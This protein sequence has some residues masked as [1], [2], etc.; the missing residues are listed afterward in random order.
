[1]AL[2][3]AEAQAQ[4]DLLIQ[5]LGGYW[6]PLANLARL[7]E[8]C[9]ELARLVNQ[10]Y[11]PKQRKSAEQTAA[12]EDELGDVLFVLAVLANSMGIELERSL[13]G[14]FAKYQARDLPERKICS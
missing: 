1:M 12:L 2:T 9:G 7:F 14:V 13:Q 8:E 5:R 6:T 4:A 10:Q 11:G 3:I